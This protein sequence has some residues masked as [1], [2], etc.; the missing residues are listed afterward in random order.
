MSAAGQSG[1]VSHLTNNSAIQWQ[2]VQKHTWQMSR[3]FKCHIVPKT[4]KLYWKLCTNICTNW[5]ISINCV[6]VHGEENLTYFIKSSLRINSRAQWTNTGVQF[7]TLIIVKFDNNRTR[8][9]WFPASFSTFYSEKEWR[10]VGY[11]AGVQWL[12]PSVLSPV[13]HWLRS[14]P[15][16]FNVN[17]N[18]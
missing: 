9:I 13:V 12:L 14:S 3:D 15:H 1:L 11:C 16:N 10:N 6:K 8:I 18:L 5:R 4:K 17:I 7:S 2:L